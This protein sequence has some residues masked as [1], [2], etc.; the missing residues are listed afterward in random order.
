MNLEN[1]KIENKN[2]E[3]V[4]SSREVAENFGKEHKNV[5]RIIKEK[6]TSAKLSSLN[7]FIEKDYI[8]SKGETK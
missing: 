7:Y 3:M 4:V 5:L 6:L 8:D 2:G 1:I